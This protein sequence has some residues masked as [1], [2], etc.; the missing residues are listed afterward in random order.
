MGGDS[1]RNFRG[2]QEWKLSFLSRTENANFHDEGIFI[3]DE[4]SFFALK[5]SWFIAK[6]LETKIVSGT[7][8]KWIFPRF[9][10][11]TTRE[12]NDF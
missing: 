9:L 7:A 8:E 12:K 3:W 6:K 4:I 1:V 11:R 10:Y 5:L 2:K